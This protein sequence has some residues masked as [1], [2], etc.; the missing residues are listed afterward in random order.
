MSNNSYGYNSNDN[1]SP[2]GNSHY[3]GNANGNNNNSND[4]NDNGNNINHQVASS[5]NAIN[6]ALQTLIQNQQFQ[7]QFQP[8]NPQ[9]QQ[10]FQQIQ[11]IQQQ[12]TS[13]TPIPT[14]TPTGNIN[15]LPLFETSK[16]AA[17]SSLSGSFQ[18]KKPKVE[19]SP[20][21][22]PSNHDR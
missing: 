19:A 8:Q 22:A 14:S 13:F 10:Q 17:V 16:R 18:T 6:M 2:N 3:N 9:F 21:Q 20:T 5:L 11:P 15:M 7:Q 4:S 1:S 12:R